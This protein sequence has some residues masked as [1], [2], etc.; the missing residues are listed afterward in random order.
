[1]YATGRNA[2]SFPLATLSDAE[3]QRFVIGNSFR[4]IRFGEEFASADG[5]TTPV[6]RAEEAVQAPV[7][8]V[9]AAV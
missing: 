6:F 5:Q 1:M 7:G 9:A 8:G 2:F 3:R 4:L